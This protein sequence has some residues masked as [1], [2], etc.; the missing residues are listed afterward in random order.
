LKVYN[1]NEITDSRLLYDKRPPR[2]LFFIILVIL[3]LIVGFI[4]WS[5]KSV[6]TFV[7]KGQ[8]IVTTEKKS[9]VM[10]KVSGEISEVYIEE[11]KK[12][13]KGDLLLVFNAPEPKY[14]LQQI[15]G[16]IEILNKRIEILERAEKEATNRINTFKR[17]DSQESE[18]YNKLVANHLKLDEYK[19]DEEALK[20]QDYTEDQIKQYK[21]Q[22]K[23]K[24]GQ[25]YYETISGFTDERKQLEIEQ[26]KLKI[27]KESISDSYE[28]YNLYAPSS[29]TIHLNTALN[30]GMVLQGGAL[31]G[32]ILVTNGDMVVEALVSS[33]D[34]PR[35]HEDNDVSLAIG[36]LSQAEYGTLKGKVISIDEDATIDSEK[37]EV[38]FK[39]K[40]KPEK[41]YLEDK[42]GE[43]V[44]LTVGMVTEIRVK[45]EKITYAKYFLEQIG[46]DCN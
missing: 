15:E 30:K 29:G 20:K 42:K 25:I 23:I 22:A 39:V 9:N 16:Q 41:T 11:G 27:Q 34:R 43:K 13:K 17:N 24:I 8:G 31:I 7:V 10:S 37:G 14:Q 4:F 36:G 18:F 6:K 44:N 38:F 3:T 5:T 1:L 21:E 35:I 33:S 45:Y 12:V 19:V 2:F 26:S 32:R 46:I 28:E 40:V